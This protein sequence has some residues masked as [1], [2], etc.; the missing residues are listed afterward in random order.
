MTTTS[1]YL[2][3]ELKAKAINPA[4]PVNGTF[5]PFV[6]QTKL[7]EQDPSRG[8]LSLPFILSSDVIHFTLP[9]FLRKSQTSFWRHRSLQFHERLSHPSTSSS[10]NQR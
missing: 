1:F 5:E 2:T 6:N 4:F 7:I 8:K 10:S 9:P 3:P